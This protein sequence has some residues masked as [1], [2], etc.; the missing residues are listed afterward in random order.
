MSIT[1]LAVVGAGLM[2]GG[3]ALDAARHGLAVKVHDSRPDGVAGLRERAAGVYARWVRNG[4]MRPEEAEAALARLLPAPALSDLADAD[5]IIEAV[6]EDLAVKRDLLATLAPHLGA[7][8]VVATNTSALEVKALSAGFG[9][10]D[11]F[12][13][14]HYFSPAEVSPLVEVV[15]ADTTSQATLARALDFLS[16]TRRTPL[17]CLDRPGFA[18]NR[19]FC[20]YYNEATRLLEEGVAGPADVDGVARD[21]LGAAAG[22]FAVMNLIRPAVAAHAMANLSRLGPFYEPSTALRAQ[23][24][25][26]MDWPVGDSR[27]GAD[28]DAVEQRLLGALALPAVELAAEG[29]ADPDAV[30][31]GAVLALKFSAGP[32]ALMRRYAAETVERAVASLCLRDGHPLPRASLAAQG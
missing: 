21:R 5:L 30:D 20:P 25:R 12:L 24:E 11:R 8:T 18:I 32:F 9:F 23:A 19:F 4:R 6:F 31:R 16:A 10:A 17:P 15:R 13:G 22:P 28:L 2:G 7:D 14:L 26:G 3:I 29:V 1:Q 27:P